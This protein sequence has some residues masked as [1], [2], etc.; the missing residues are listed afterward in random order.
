LPAM[1]ADL[2]A[3]A[4]EPQFVVAAIGDVFLPGG[5]APVLTDYL[6]AMSATFWCTLLLLTGTFVLALRLPGTR[7]ASASA[8]VRVRGVP[9]SD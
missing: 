2:A 7:I 5:D 9:S 6:A 3:T 1:R 4:G 8:L